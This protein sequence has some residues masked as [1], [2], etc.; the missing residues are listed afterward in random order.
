LDQKYPIQNFCNISR[1]LRSISFRPRTP[2]YQ[3]FWNVFRMSV[4]SYARTHQFQNFWK[5]S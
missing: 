5:S 2:T 4:C 3:N 1:I